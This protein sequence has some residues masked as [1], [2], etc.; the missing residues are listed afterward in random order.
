MEQAQR[1]VTFNLKE[2]NNVDDLVN[3][4]LSKSIQLMNKEA[5][6]KPSF[7]S[8]M[9]GGDVEKYSYDS[10]CKI[11]PCISFDPKNIELVSG[12]KFPDI[13]IDKTIYGVEIKSTQKD[14]WTST[15]SSIVESTRCD[16]IERI[17]M[18]FGK[19]GGHPE[20][21]CKPY[22]F[23]LSNIAVTHSPRYLIDMCLNENDNIFSKLNI[24]YDSFRKLN[25]NE[26]ICHVR[27]FLKKR[28]K[29][30]KQEKDKYEMP[31]WLGETTNANLRFFNDVDE[32]IQ[33]NLI[34]R[35]YILFPS[36]LFSNDKYK[37]K[38]AS[39]WLCTR[40]SILA[41][42]I[43]DLFSAG[44]KI[45]Q[46]GNRILGKEYPKILENL[47]KEMPHIL[48]LLDNPDEELIN[49]IYDFWDFKY[50]KYDLLNSW[51]L[52]LESVFKKNKDLCDLDI[53][54]LIYED[55]CK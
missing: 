26:K 50:D 8:K 48:K 4:L 3:E 16:G 52:E 41:Y 35:M 49:D 42:N 10:I 39:L 54:I 55:F 6:E 51:I 11:A 27:D 17:F 15:G 30:I 9:T 43:R 33:E 13:I 37:Y 22:Q 29:R 34:A 36:F 7:Y 20:F 32:K 40:H 21:R 38:T 24:E 12:N 31:W 23:C 2:K 45:T 5:V 25:E 53:M 28:A 1:F 19:L 14:A 44:G 18:L 47:Y 46:V